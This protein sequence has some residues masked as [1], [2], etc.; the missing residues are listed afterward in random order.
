MSGKSRV[1][2]AE[3]PQIIKK[4]YVLSAHVTWIDDEDNVITTNIDFQ[5]GTTESYIN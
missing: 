5:L 1:E 3:S 4:V 2:V